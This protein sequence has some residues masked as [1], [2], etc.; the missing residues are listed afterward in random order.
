MELL[1]LPTRKFHLQH[2]FEIHQAYLNQHSLNTF[3][4]FE[5]QHLKMLSLVDLKYDLLIFFNLNLNLLHLMKMTILIPL[6]LNFLKFKAYYDLL[7][8]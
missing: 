3:F 7:W 8:N 6:L 4:S 5:E 2:L 1:F